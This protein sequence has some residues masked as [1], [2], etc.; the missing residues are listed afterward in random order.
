MSRVPPPRWSRTLLAFLLPWTYRDEVLGD[1]DEGYRR[2]GKAGSWYRQEV[3]RSIPG[4]LRLRWQTRNDLHVRDGSMESV[5]QDLRYALRSLIK[6]PGFAIVS[7]LTLALA[8]G[9][10]TSIFSLV[11]VVVFADLPMQDEATAAVVRG[12]NAELGVDQGSVS[13]ADYLD[14][15]ARARSYESLSAV[16]E[17]QLVLGGDEPARVQGLLATV[18]LF[19]TWRLPPFL[20]REFVEGEDREG[21]ERVAMLTH[22][23]WEE[24]YGG[25]RGVLGTVLELDGLEYTVVGVTHP[26][27]EF[28]SFAEAEVVLPLVIDRSSPDRTAR[29][30]FVVGRLATGVSHAAAEEEARAIGAQ[31]ADEWP[32]QNRGWALWS[33]PVMD[34]LIDDDGNRILLMLQI[35]VA[36]VILIAC[37]NVANMLLARASVRAREIAVRSALGAERKR[38]VRQL[39]TESLVISLMAA[40]M[41]LVFAGLLNRALVWISAGTE[42]VLLMAEL[43]GRVLAFTLVVSLVA[44]MVFGL[45]PAL[46][47][48]G[49]SASNT[50]RD[51]RSSGSS[52]SGRRMRNGL[53]TAQIALAVTLMVVAT[54]VCRTVININS[55]PLGYEIEDFLT[56]RS[57]LPEGG[58]QDD[59]ATLA[60]Y[61]DASEA[62]A[63]TPR[64]GTVALSSSLPGLEFGAARSV[65]IEGVQLPEGRAAPRGW[66]HYVSQN[67]FDVVGL[68][69]LRGR[70]FTDDDRA[71]SFPVAVISL[72]VAEQFWPDEDPVG[73]RLRIAESEDWLNVV[74]VVS[75]VRSP[76]GTEDAS[77]AIYRPHV[78]DAR[79][80]MY[81][82]TRTSGAPEELA[83]PIR[84]AVWSVD[85]QLPVG[86]I[87]SMERAQYEFRASDYALVTLFVTF[88]V[89]ALVMAGVGIYGVM[90]YSVSQR[91]K[92]IGLRMALGAQV[93]GV[94]RM[95]MNQGVRIL[96]V[97]IV[98]GLAASLLVGRLLESLLYGVTSSDPLTL[99]GVPVVLT[100][101]AL[102]ANMIPAS[103][104]TRFDPATTLRGD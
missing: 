79:R 63:N 3:L 66:F 30:L 80:A 90:A 24:R 23:F 86:P 89:F 72:E 70:G 68:D 73:R 14:L 99:I 95:V 39:L 60:F 64:L 5:S 84:E 8:I 6:S 29:Y 98:I 9:V 87:R 35:T 57:E 41:G 85:R 67:F 33:A 45:V 88:A 61:T 97:G 1:L 54:L 101:V 102:I 77:R 78:Q 4:A 100:L 40:A 51:A 20:G 55:R 2:R 91:R 50:L 96:A 82:L 37:A 58:Y 25:D 74:G 32:A 56:V 11:N 26:K 53:A 21:A 46:R 93:G 43:D 65:E 27:L 76:E 42:G 49:L 94:R 38:L 18:G 103:R 7:T 83:G 75:N 104:A 19:H 16:T 71:T 17:S 15:V 48:S 59:E 52:R 28:A 92:E 44:P 12:T 62:L 31:L 34:S 47:A 22:G 13:P 81:F 10:N 69:V 36:M